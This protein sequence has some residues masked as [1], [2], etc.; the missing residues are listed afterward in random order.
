MIYDAKNEV[1]RKSDGHAELIYYWNAKN[2]C[3]DVIRQWWVA[4]GEDDV[5]CEWEI[6]D[7]ITEVGQ[8]QE[9]MN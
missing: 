1:F 2:Y 4:N 5:D 6:V 7:Y 8:L 9:E 3:I